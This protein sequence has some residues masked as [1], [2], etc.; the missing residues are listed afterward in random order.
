MAADAL[1]Q[2]ALLRRLSGELARLHSW[3]DVTAYLMGALVQL[4]GGNTASLCLVT[5]N[6]D[7]LQIV[8]E[9]GYPADVTDVWTRFPLDAS[10]PA[11]EAVREGQAV[12][13]TSPE[14]RNTRYPV[15]AD[16]PVVQDSAYAIEPLIADGRTLG[17]LVIGFEE[18]KDF[19]ADEQQLLAA[20]TAR[21]A[22]ALAKRR[23][24]T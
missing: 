23:R 17:A 15:F 21:C 1:D 5:E 6:G 19:T 14:D 20:A 22:E 24:R 16:G 10:L 11:S 7:E 12:F 2:N 4:V 18:S 9:H 13:I 3:E 8:A